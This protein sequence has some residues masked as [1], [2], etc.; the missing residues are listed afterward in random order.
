[1]LAI[2]N[3][4]LYVIPCLI[5]Q[6][7]SHSRGSLNLSHYSD[8]NSLKYMSFLENTRQLYMLEC[9]LHLSSSLFVVE[10]PR[11]IKKPSVILLCWPF[12]RGT[13]GVK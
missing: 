2:A 5:H 11:S 1:M 6:T 12:V 13:H 7:N 4:W 3:P 10:K 9:E 8:I